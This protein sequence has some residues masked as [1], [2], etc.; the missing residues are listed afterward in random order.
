MPNWTDTEKESIREI[1]QLNLTQ[2]NEDFIDATLA[3]FNDA[4][5]TAITAD[6]A[7]WADVQYG[8]TKTKGGQRGTDYDTNRERLYITNRMRSRFDM[9]QLA[10]G[11]GD[12]IFSF[13]MRL[14]GS[15]DYGDPDTE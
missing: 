15:F 1:L 9:A 10:D 12:S 8:T 11:S 4:H 6:I 5:K 7:Q 13:T 14:P 3:T 2:A